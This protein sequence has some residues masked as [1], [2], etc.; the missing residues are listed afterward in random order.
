MNAIE[1]RISN[2]VEFE[3][4]LCKVT[5]IT[6]MYNNAPYGIEVCFSDGIFSAEDLTPIPLTEEWL[7]KFGFTSHRSIMESLAKFE[8]ISKNSDK[9]GYW[10]VYFRQ[11]DETVN[12]YLHLNDLV[13]LKRNLMYVHQLQNLYFALTGEELQIKES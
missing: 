7:L 6:Q 10:Y 12:D 4:R 5:G 9:N 2:L 1:F 3:G 13:L 8:M 11:G